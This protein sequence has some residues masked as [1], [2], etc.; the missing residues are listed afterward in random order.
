MQDGN[1]CKLLNSERKYCFSGNQMH[2]IPYAFS[3]I[4]PED[5]RVTVLQ[6]LDLLVQKIIVFFKC[7]QIIIDTPINKKTN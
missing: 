2:K 5:G 6:A 3:G 7:T 4:T 1:H